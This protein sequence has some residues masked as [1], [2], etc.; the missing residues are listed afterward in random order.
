MTAVSRFEADL[1]R[2]LDALL[3]RGP[4]EGALPVIVSRREPPPCLGRGAVALVQ[5][6]LA[7]GVTWRLA[8]R[9]AWRPERHLRGDRV[10]SGRLWQRTDPEDLAL[11]FSRRTLEFLIWLTARHPGDRSGRWSA[12]PEALTVGDRLVIFEAFEALRPFEVHKHFLEMPEFARDGLCRVAFPDDFAGI[13]PGDPPDFA[14]WVEGVGACVLES[15]QAM[16]VRR[17]VEVE[18]FK[19]QLRDAATMTALGRSQER[20]LEALLDAVDRVGRRDLARFLLSAASTLLGD[21]RAPGA[22]VGSLNLVGLRLADRAEVHRDALVFL[23]S[24]DRLRSWERSSRD[25]GY[26]DEGYVASQ[27]W[28]ADWEASNGE[29]LCDRAADVARAVDPMGP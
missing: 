21:D 4:V 15:F 7:K 20:V 10:A 11:S 12:N 9:G 28:K 2:L 6:R 18:R 5:E 23:R 1:L 26:F 25:V 24:L 8:R 19:G 27:L 13:D 16:L 17:W 22:W 14:P 3:G 29:R